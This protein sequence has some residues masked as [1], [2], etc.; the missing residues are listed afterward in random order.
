MTVWFTADQHFGHA[1]IIRHCG[2]PFSDVVEMDEAMIQRWNASV[3]SDDEVWHL[4]NFAYRCGPNRMREIYSRLRGRA[5]HLVRGNHDSKRTLELPWASVQRYAE[6]KVDCQLLILFHYGLRV[7][8]RS[9][10][11]SWSLYGHSYG[12]LPGTATSCDVGVDAWDF[13]PVSI[14]EIRAALANNVA[15]VESSFLKE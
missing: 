7:W 13:R 12:K 14:V 15:T 8:H 11:G 4:G 5:L 9:H 10:H 3:G 6:I 2:R 1:N